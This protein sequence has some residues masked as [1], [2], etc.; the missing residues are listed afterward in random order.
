VKKMRRNAKEGR[1][2]TDDTDKTDE[3]KERW[4]GA[5]KRRKRMR[6]TTDDASNRRPQP[7]GKYRRQDNWID[8]IKYKM[9]EK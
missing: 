2:T 5:E 8:G 6:R 3:W 9:E 7:K 4:S 1:R